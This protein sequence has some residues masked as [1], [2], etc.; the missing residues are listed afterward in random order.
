MDLIDDI[1][2][3]K[4][5][6]GNNTVACVGFVPHD[7]FHEGHKQL[8]AKARKLAQK[9]LILV[10]PFAWDAEEDDRSFS[11]KGLQT[12][13]AD[14]MFF[15][16]TA[17]RFSQRDYVSYESLYKSWLNQTY[18]VYSF[19][20]NHGIRVTHT[21]FGLKEPI[22]RARQK[23]IHASLGIESIHLPV[24]K[25][26]EG[27]PLYV[28]VMS[29]PQLARIAKQVYAAKTK[30]EISKISGVLGCFT[31]KEA[32]IKER[33]VEIVDDKGNRETL[34]FTV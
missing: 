29:S 4:K 30:K 8:L 31:V 22:L 10:Y 13:T 25:D 24:V 23:E 14:A 3:L 1:T 12:L 6:L 28:A 21:V 17:V 34:K 5:V 19:L 16:S 32:G 2:K 7:T 9:V 33:N 18:A 11:V 20:Q 15:V 26:K 27:L